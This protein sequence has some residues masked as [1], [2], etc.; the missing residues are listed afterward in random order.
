MPLLFEQYG[1]GPYALELGADLAIQSPDL[2]SAGS[3]L[4]GVRRRDGRLRIR[5]PL[6]ITYGIGGIYAEVVDHP[7]VGPEDLR[8]FAL[9]PVTAEQFAGIAKFR[10]RIPTSVPWREP[11]PSNRPSPISSWARRRSCWP[12]TT[13][14]ALKA[15][16]RDWRTGHR[17]HA[18]D[19]ARRGGHVF[20]RTT[21]A[22][23]G[24]LISMAMWRR[25]PSPHLKRMVE[26]VHDAGALFMLHPAATRSL[27]AVTM[28]R[29]AS[30]SSNRSNPRRTTPLP[31]PTSGTATGWPLPRGSTSSAASR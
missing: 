9:P 11:L 16:M 31:S 7:I 10:R 22:R 25:S 24:P 29:R 27:P 4:S 26:A 6:G 8:T 5:G 2:T 14:G 13:T 30:T 20:C 3:F 19:G 23:G 18:A 15:F 12:S 28:W 21:M 1:N 17:H